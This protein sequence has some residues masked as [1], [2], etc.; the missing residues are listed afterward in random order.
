MI[1]KAED[2]LRLLHCQKNPGPTIEDPSSMEH[3]NIP[4][5]TDQEQEHELETKESTQ[6]TS[7][8]QEG[9][10]PNTSGPEISRTDQ[11]KQQQ[12][13]QHSSEPSTTGEPLRLVTC[14]QASLIDPLEVHVEVP[15]VHVAEPVLTPIECLRRKD[16]IIKQ[17]LIEKQL[18]VAD[19][20]KYSKRRFRTR[21]RHGVRAIEHGKRTF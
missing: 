17:A 21:S 7:V 12:P 11:T 20:I 1:S 10:L 14:T 19:N 18:L 4:N 5:K 3:D 8:E 6:D 16:E 13:H 2:L 9:E 15:P